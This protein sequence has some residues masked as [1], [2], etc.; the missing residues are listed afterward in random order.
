MHQLI[1]D[2][3]FLHGKSSSLPD[4]TMKLKFAAMNFDQYF[5][6]LGTFMMLRTIYYFFFGG[7]VLFIIS[8]TTR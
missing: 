8:S 2:G 1:S 3:N 5:S 6:V 4:G 7:S